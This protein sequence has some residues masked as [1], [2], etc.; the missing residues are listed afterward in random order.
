V[1]KHFI[2]NIKKMLQFRF[3]EDMQREIKQELGQVITQW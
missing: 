3:V 2:N 1:G